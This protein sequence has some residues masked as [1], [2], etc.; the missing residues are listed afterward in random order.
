[1]AQVLALAAPV[2]SERDRKKVIT[3]SY[4]VV[5]GYLGSTPTIARTT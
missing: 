3:N 4:I 5:S 2:D 1:M